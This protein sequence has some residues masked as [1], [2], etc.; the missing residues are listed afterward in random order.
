MLSNDLVTIPPTPA[1]EADLFRMLVDN[2][3]DY[4][5][6]ATSLDGRVLTWNPGAERVLGYA[7]GEIIGTSAFITFTP[8]DRANGVPEREL[9]TAIREGRAGDDRWHLRKDGTRIWVNG[10]LV[11]LKD[12]A[13]IPHA[14][15]KVMRD[16]TEMKLAQERLRESEERLRVALSAARMGTWLWRIPQDDQVIDETLHEMMGLAPGEEVRTLESFLRAVHNEDRGRVRAEFER[17]RSEG[18]DFDVEFRVQRPTGIRWLKDQG[19][20]FPGPEGHPL[21]VTG[22]CVDITDRRE[23][24]EEMREANRSK[25][26]FLAMLGHELRNPLAPLRG[27]I[28][29]LRRKQHD[30]IGLA[31]AHAMMERQVGHLTRLVDDL[32]DV[33]RITRGL[34]ELRKEK[35]NLSEVVNEAVEMA[36]PAIDGRRHN[37]NLSLPHKPLWVEGDSTRLTQVIFNLLNNAA[38]FTDPGGRIWLSIES[39]GES[40]VLRV[41]DSGSGMKAELVAKVFDI[42]TQGERTPDRSQ[43]GLGLGLT[44]VKRLVEMHGGSVEAQSEGPGEGS[45]FTVR[46]P[47]LPIEPKPTPVQFP[48][49]SPATVQVARALVID[50][51]AD[52]AESMTWVLEGLAGEVKIAHSGPAALDQVSGWSPDIIF[53]D[54]GMPKMDGY[55]TCRRLRQVP[56]LEKVVIVAVSGYGSEDDRRK[57]HEA[58]FDHHLVKPIGLETLEKLVRSVAKGG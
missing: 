22:A 12:E 53:C 18:G 25:D 44:L 7:E 21:F 27:V 30:D 10:V 42:F 14:C 20:A 24:E 41:R 46:L 13:G 49:S 40:A 6:F 4:A 35:V 34:V 58:G 8:E 45:E 38:K 28:E 31:R 17:C 43:G 16:L 54:I 19:R 2:T 37:L 29:T 1:W 48:S 39:E 11:L 55:E 15:G 5:V 50:D 56:D 51:N 23:M 57:S 26:E 32:L 9:Q 3:R 52:I 47:A 33:S 36:T